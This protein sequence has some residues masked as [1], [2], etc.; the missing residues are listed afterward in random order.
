M[1]RA[2]TNELHA[3]V[4]ADG[5]VKG[6][7]SASVLIAD[8]NRTRTA[9][10]R[11]QLESI[12]CGPIRC[13]GDVGSVCD[14]VHRMKP[15]LLILREEW[16]AAITPSL[17][18][19]KAAAALLLLSPRRRERK[20]GED[21]RDLFRR[22]DYPVADE[23]LR[24]RVAGALQAFDQVRQERDRQERFGGLASLLADYACSVSVGKNAQMAREW[25]TGTLEALSGYTEEEC[26][27]RGGWRS[28]IHPEDLPLADAQ[29]RILLGGQ[30]V[31]R[32]LR[33]VACDGSARWV[34]VRGR[35]ERDGETG[36]ISRIV[37][38]ATDVTS[39]QKIAQA[40]AESE[41][42]WKFA[43]EASGD[44]V[45]DWDVETGEVYHSDR[46]CQLTGSPPQELSHAVSEWT[47]RVHPEDR[48]KFTEDIRRYFHGLTPDY[49]TEY[50]LRGADGRYLWV[51]DRAKVVA[52]TADGRPRRV[53]GSMADVT[54]RKEDADRLARSNAFLRD[55]LESS[56][57]VAIVSTDA[58][59]VVEFWNSG[60]ERILGYA[61]ASVVG[62]KRL[63]G[64]LF[65]SP[66]EE[67]RLDEE[68]RSLV[69]GSG[70]TLSR[71]VQLRR[72]S[73]T[74]VWVRATISA[75]IDAGGSVKGLL[76]IGEDLTPQVEAQTV[77]K[78]RER[79]LRLLAFTLNC[80]REGFCITDLRYRI[81]YVNEA[82]RLTYGYAEDELLGQSVRVLQA[83]GIGRERL[84][85]IDAETRQGGWS[86]EIPCRRKDG[87]EFPAEVSIAV[88]RND[89]GEPVALV[90]VARDITERVAAAER[91]RNS[92]AEKEVM[93]KEIHHRVKNNLQVISSLLNLQS[94]QEQDP[95]IV[96][97]LKESQGRVRSMALVHEELYRSTD[98][99]D[100]DME[101]YVRKLANNLFFAYQSSGT[102][103]T[104]DIDVHDVY[105][106]VDAAVP[107][108]LI[109]N[110]LI[111]NSLKYAFGKR[112]TGVITV[113]LQRE[114]DSCRLMVGD[115]GVGL[116]SE[117]DIEHS[118]S[119]GLQLVF[120]LAK[121]LHA[122]LEVNRL[123]GTSFALTFVSH[124]K[125]AHA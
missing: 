6:V 62:V 45:W 123:Q 122:R 108:G 59:G 88:V 100:I 19:G 78:R 35:A 34:R 91:I 95:A 70:Q 2:R 65:A 103:V 23:V 69:I 102:R 63:S 1:P 82:L 32:R 110:E 33:I 39:E 114:R 42:R 60:A 36:R 98:L 125:H 12:S 97:A 89:D 85:A 28:L 61:A 3:G 9:A 87:S 30:E 90:G 16:V 107:C 80:A 104:L 77:S 29:L 116:P 50:R 38:A 109:I 5:E 73:G 117:L 113:R 101:S 120:I 48:K 58:E 106:P 79:E 37:I 83:P 10:L 96:A 111:S 53:I 105:L 55:I 52:W 57:T 67:S 118:E 41:M 22:L 8:S 124:A 18:N 68:V 66:E 54:A 15:D 86:G 44:A 14:E 46:W 92:L 21:V 93:L 27:R 112:S 119:L 115:D 72:H 24:L 47:E 99:A 11:R 25:S 49:E 26:E 31:D 64:V 20:T 75:R 94:S 40:L 71:I 7:K 76:I 51:L 74:D 17:V 84:R 81:L 4:R 13:V 43:L 56:P 121:Q